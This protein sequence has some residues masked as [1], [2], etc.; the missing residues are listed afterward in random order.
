M[1]KPKPPAGT[2]KMSM[3]LGTAALALTLA[4]CGEVIEQATSAGTGSSAATGSGG[5]GGAPAVCVPQDGGGTP[6]QPTC[7]DLDVMTVSHPAFMD[8]SGDGKL[9]FD[10][11]GTL[12]VNLNEVAGQ[13]FNDY[14]GVSFTSDVVS[15]DANGLAQFY[16]I[17]PCQSE[18][19]SVQISLLT[20]VPPGTVV[21]M[22][23]QVAMLGAVC[24]DAPSISIPIVIE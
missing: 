17:L 14:P 1:A 2:E 8:D 19:A 20:H 21:Q 13:G 23:A 18:K 22:K 3:R 12:T 9:A 6:L 10:E 24:P 7:A 15:V 11:S 16:A 5:A 4:A